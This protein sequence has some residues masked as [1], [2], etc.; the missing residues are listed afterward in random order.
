MKTLTGARAILSAAHRSKDGILHGHTWEVIAW[1]E[2]CP[3]AGQKQ[4]ELTD[5]LKVFDHSVL[6]DGIA[7]GEKLAETI[8]NGLGCFKVQI[9]RPLEGIFAEVTR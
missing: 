7:W 8:C 6:A 3:D 4:A 5:Y 2:G 1:W 9:N